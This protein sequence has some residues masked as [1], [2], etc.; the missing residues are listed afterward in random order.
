MSPKVERAVKASESSIKE[1][2]NVVRVVVLA[3]PAPVKYGRAS[4]AEVNPAMA[5]RSASY[6]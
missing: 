1:R 4:T 6:A 2:P 3:V 5:V